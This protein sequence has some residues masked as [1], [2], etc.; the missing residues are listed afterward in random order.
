MDCFCKRRQEKSPYLHPPYNLPATY[1]PFGA[2]MFST[3]ITRKPG[4]NFAQGITTANLGVPSFSRT[5]EQHAAYVQT[6]R[7][8]GLNVI[9]LEPLPDYPDAYFVEDVAVVTPDVAIITSPGAEERKGEQEF[10]ELVLAQYRELAHIEPPGTVDGGDVLMVGQHFFIG[11]S[12]RTN[13]LGAAQL[14]ET[15]E[16]FGY[17]WMSVPVEAGLHLKSSVNWVGENNLLISAG[18]SGQP[19]F[20]NY[21][22]IVVDPGEE[23]ACNTLWINGNLLTPKGFLKTRERLSTLGLPIIE[24]ETSEIQKMDGGLTCMSLR[25]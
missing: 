11:V 5:L 21:T 20:E 22:Q 4:E 18:F 25:F 24:M 12:E 14:G 23:Y 13:P 2:F 1:L 15:L 8:I 6:L 3:A 9:E 7:K 10:I 16:R 17:T 19:E